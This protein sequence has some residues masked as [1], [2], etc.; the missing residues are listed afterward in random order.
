MMLVWKA[1]EERVL[2]TPTVGQADDFKIQAGEFLFDVVMLCR[3]LLQGIYY[4]KRSGRKINLGACRGSRD[5][6]T[7]SGCKVMTISLIVGAE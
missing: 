4:E 6:G 1:N 7:V 3:G 5:L 2:G